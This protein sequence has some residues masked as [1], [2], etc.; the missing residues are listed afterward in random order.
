MILTHLWHWDKVKVIKP[1]MY[2]QTQSK[3]I[4]MQTLRPPFYSVCKKRN[5]KVFVKS[6]NSQLYPLNMFKK[7]QQNSGIFMIYSTFLTILQH[8]NLF[9][10]KNEFFS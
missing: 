5:V 1:G 3:V 6:G 2:W 9:G 10:W 8:F 7:F 4:I